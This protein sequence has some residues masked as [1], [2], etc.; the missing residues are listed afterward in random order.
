MPPS[1]PT[2]N[3]QWIDEA[4]AR[5]QAPLMR[6]AAHLL[7]G[8]SGAVSRAADVVQET[9]AKLCAQ[10]E[11][12]LSSRLAAWL[13]AVCRSTALDVRRKEKRMT[14][15]PDTH[16]AILIDPSPDPLENAETR[17]E[18]EN[19]LRRL[20]HLPRNQ[21]EV[22]RLKFQAG[23]SYQ[24]ISDVTKLSVTN[25]GFLLHT[26]IKTLRKSAME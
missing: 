6:Y 11:A 19:V 22:V 13:F 3:P 1:A 4:V 17:D 26:A 15:L 20:A 16:A 18:A 10:D 21:Q 9:F 12:E 24:E 8:T 23:L 5:Y 2:V 7:G 25:V 14:I